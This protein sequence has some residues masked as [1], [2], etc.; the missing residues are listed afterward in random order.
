MSVN[1]LNFNKYEVLS[2]DCYG[3]IIDWESSILFEIRK[4]LLTHNLSLSDI[5]ILELYAKLE[6]KAEEGEFHNYKTVLRTVMAE[7]GKEFGFRPNQQEL[8]C[9]AESLENWQPFSDTVEAL[10]VLKKKYKLQS[11]QISIMICF[12]FQK[13]IFR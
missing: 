4:V 7:I 12:C 9:L 11:Y 10:Q 3:T 2:F 5:Q 13:V 1:M 6:S 8:N